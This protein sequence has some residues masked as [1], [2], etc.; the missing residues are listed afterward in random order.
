MD[1]IVSS[2]YLPNCCEFKVGKAEGVA[3]W[4]NACLGSSSALPNQTAEQQTAV[5]DLQAH[6]LAS[7]LAEFTKTFQDCR[8]ERKAGI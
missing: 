1:T 8:M 5:L 7:L 3:Q 2:L 6:M 4:V